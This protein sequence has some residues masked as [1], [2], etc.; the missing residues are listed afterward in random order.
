MLRLVVLLSTTKIKMIYAVLPQHFLYLRPLPQ[1]Q[2]SLRPIFGVALV[3]GVCGGGQQL[4]SLQPDSSGAID[5]VDKLLL[6]SLMWITHS[7]LTL[8]Y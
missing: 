8:K 1:I 6:L 5:G 4:V 7:F 3:I 2:G